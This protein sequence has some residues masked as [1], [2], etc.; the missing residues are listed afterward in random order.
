MKKV[1]LIIVLFACLSVLIPGTAQASSHPL[2]EW[3]DAHPPGR[4]WVDGDTCW[5]FDKGAIGASDYVLVIEPD[6]TLDID[7][8]FDNNG[9]VDN[10]G[11]INIHPGGNLA[12]VGGTLYNYGTIDNS[13]YLWGGFNGTIDNGGVINNNSGG[14]LDNGDGTL[15][16]NGT[17]NNFDLFYNHYNGTIANNSGGTIANNGTISNNGAI[18]NYGIIYNRGSCSGAPIINMNGGVVYDE[19][20]YLPIVV[21]S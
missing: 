7:A 15:Y 9:T 8:L 19:F 2:K 20:V 16:N 12:N 21:R 17:I 6:E 18:D 13:G 3:C 14:T 11:T 5:V 1:T 4:T 10:Y